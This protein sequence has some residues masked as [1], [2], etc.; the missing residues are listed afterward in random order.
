MNKYCLLW[1]VCLFLGACESQKKGAA[2]IFELLPSS[3]TGISFR[4]DLHENDSL[5]YFTYPYIYM[6][7]GVAVG[8]LNGDGLEDLY[9]TANMQSNALYLNRG[10]LKFE[11]VT[12]TSSVA[13]DNR[14][15][16]GVTLVDI[17]QDGRL[18]IY[19]SVSGLFGPFGNLLYVNQ[20]ND[21]EGI[22]S[23]E[24]QGEA[25]G[26]ADLGHTTQ[27][28]FFDADNDGDL[29]LYV[30]NYPITN[31]KVPTAYYSYQMNNPILD[32]SS[33]FYKN[34]N[35]RYVDQTE[36]S[37]LLSFGL[38]LSA[39]VGDFNNDGYLDIY[40]S[41]DFASPDFC[42]IN[43]GD[44]T[45]VE[46][47]KTVT[48]QTSFYGMGS[49]A[50]DYNN[51]GLLDI[52]QVD[53]APESH[54]RSKENMASMNPEGFYEMVDKSLHY[55]YMFNC[56]QLNQ[57]IDTEG[58][59][60]Y[61]NVVQMAHTAKTDWSWAP[62]FADLDNDGLKDLFITNGTRRDI[63]NRDFF[64]RT[65]GQNYFGQK[66][67]K[68]TLADLAEMPSEAVPNY[69]FKNK[70]DLTFGKMAKNWGLDQPSFSNGAVYADL[71]NDGD[72][73]LVVNNIDEDVFV[74][75]NHSVEMGLGNYLT[76]SL[77][78]TDKNLAGIGAR[79]TIYTPQGLQ[80][81][82]VMRARGFQSAVAPKAHFGLGAVDTI[83]KVEVDWKNGRRS[84]VE[85]VPANQTLV[86]KATDAEPYQPV[87]NHTQKVF[88][89]VA[90]VF[91]EEYVHEE[92]SF[93]DFDR[94]PLLPHKMSNFGPALATG[95][96]N[97]DGLPDVYVGGALG[98]AG[99][100]F[101]QN[102]NG[103]FES[104]DTAFWQLE[105]LSEDLDALFVDLDQDGDLDLYVVSGGNELRSTDKRLKD[106]LYLN[107]GQGH[108]SNHSNLLPDLFESGGKVVAFDYDQDGDQD[109]FLGTRL[110]PGQYPTPAS[111]YLLENQIEKGSL[112]FENVT[113]NRAPAFKDLGMVTDAVSTDFDQDGD[114]DLV[115]TGEWMPISFF[116]NQ[117]GRFVPRTDDFGFG[118]SRGWW[119]SIEAADMDGDGDDD[120]LVGNLGENYKY[121]ASP[122]ST[123]DIYANDYDDNG[124]IDIV[125]SYYQNGTQLPVRGRQCSSEQ[126]PAIKERFKDYTSFADATLVD[127]YSASMLAQSLHYE[128]GSFASIYLENVG[129]G[130]FKKHELP[131]E[132][133][134]MPI[135]DYI[136]QDFNNDGNLDVVLA[137]NLFASEVETPRAD[138][139]RGLLMYGDGQGSFQPQPYHR[140]G[141]NW[142]NDVKKLA[143]ANTEKGKIIFV[144][145]NQGPVQAVQ[146]IVLENQ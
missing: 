46:Q 55:Q 45:F 100:L 13:G 76:V 115:V 89:E 28:S 8:D 118:D 49:D 40:V 62:L 29:D 41:N 71:D 44:G 136:I 107:D 128:V 30:A 77:E 79:V 56:L 97:A 99:T 75:K 24:E 20:G 53:M 58:L 82:E 35:G 101:I 83:T 22:P 132:A 112:A 9:F 38:S 60:M 91:I 114:L 3:S 80:T 10:Q 104:F 1:V 130:K 119:F 129:E 33:H 143:M 7:G 111:S 6:G 57:G 94:E 141:I 120:Y 127:I 95:D 123:F 48:N 34:E 67:K 137:G 85:Q 23:F 84:V 61:S 54:K 74:Y 19:V 90:G 21:S 52:I 78:G 15:M 63:N 16:T 109:L 124:Q 116:E 68:N 72:L 140:S 51:D 59:P 27:A 73:E 110:I 11:D 125:L 88:E 108:F 92:N 144:A 135:N 12:E 145:N 66:A 4:N 31:F 65:E 70:G 39:S 113:E 98:R 2:K 131:K 134:M 102:K 86:V 25:Y 126:V 133:Q 142:A 146:W 81:V 96:V 106:R 138:A 93:N 18:D 36:A 17:N 87:P 139:G 64:R 14:W 26:I 105:K 37:G 50:A 43:Q 122:E 121:H 5:N 47:V 103:M 117:K 42:Y 69:A 32:H